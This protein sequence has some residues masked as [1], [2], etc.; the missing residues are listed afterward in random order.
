[1]SP[2]NRVICKVPG[3][4]SN[5]GSGFDTLGLG[6]SIYNKITVERVGAELSDR[7]DLGV[8]IFPES[9]M[10]QDTATHFFKE[11][12]VEPF[13]VRV[14]II[15]DVPRA[16]GLGSS[17]TVR[18]GILAGL[19]ALAGV[20]FSKKREVEVVTELEGHPDNASASILGGFTVSRFLK[21]PAVHHHTIRF[22]IGEDLR[23]LVVSPEFEVL[24]SSSRGIL[25]ESLSFADAVSSM[26]NATC[27]VAAL[28]SGNYDELRDVQG[29][30]FHEP[31][32]LNGIPGAS[33]AIR[34]GIDAGAY[35][36][37][38]SGSGS[39]VLC[40]CSADSVDSV[41]KAM[42][43]A[44]SEVGLESVARDLSADN[45]GIRILETE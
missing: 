28:A 45:Q 29:D 23:F 13:E 44:F 39:S 4:T 25:P 30:S 9:T 27:M 3:S 20:V 6:L 33:D 17:V 41:E 18:G 36:G 42:K 37:W 35:T 34:V 16:R 24:T 22:E 1:M 2:C 12:G 10:A 32:R 21:N 38:L 8:D 15:G 19:S 7:G 26:N 5:C 11:T 40:A 14:R 43:A 31:H